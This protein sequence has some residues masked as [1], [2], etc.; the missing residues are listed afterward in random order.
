MINYNYLITIF[1]LFSEGGNYSRDEVKILK[2]KI[3]KIQKQSK[4]KFTKILDNNKQ[5]QNDILSK[6]LNT[7]KLI[8]D[9]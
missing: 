4:K 9:R 6:F 1:R 2:K 8:L 7:E 3:T 5:K